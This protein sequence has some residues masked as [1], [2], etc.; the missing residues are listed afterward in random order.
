MQINV[1]IIIMQ[2]TYR[3]VALVAADAHSHVTFCEA[4]FAD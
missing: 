4:E 1:I 3:R 2:N